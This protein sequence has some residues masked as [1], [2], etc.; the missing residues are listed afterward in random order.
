MGYYVH[1]FSVDMAVLLGLHEAIVLQHFHHWHMLNEGVE[2]MQRDGKTW[3]FLSA[4][5]V[6]RVFPYLSERKIR[7]AI[8]HLIEKGYI[9]KD[10]AKGYNR[11]KWYALTEDGQAL[12]LPSYKMSNACDKM[13]NASY[14]MSND[15]DNNN[16]YNNKDNN[17]S[18]SEGKEINKENG[19]FD[20]RSALIEYGIS[21]ELADA[22]LEVRKNKRAT[23]SQIA[24]DDTIR[25]IELSGYPADDCIRMAV[26]KSW[27]GFKAAWMH[28]AIASERQERKGKESTFEKNL[29]TIDD[30]FGSDYHTHYYGK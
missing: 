24:Y 26:V 25:Q 4:A 6:R 20:F 12:F 29:R 9:V 16:I 30:M 11:S 13:S 27:S 2:S 8:E 19:K 18:I 15:I 3:F 22:W 1:A 7:T 10:D 21:P 14:E 17:I 23:N 28:N 5:R